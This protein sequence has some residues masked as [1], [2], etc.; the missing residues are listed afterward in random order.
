MGRVYAC[1][2]VVSSGVG[3]G[4]C[5]GCRCTPKMSRKIF[6]VAAGFPHIPICH[7]CLNCTKFGL[8]ILRK[9]IKIVATMQMSY[10]KAKMH[11]IRF[12]LGPDP[13]GGAY[14]TPPYPLA[15][16]RGPT[17]KGLSLIHI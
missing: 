8:L 17:S 11:Q 5:T 14:S 10:F 9:I 4:G 13:V 3:R 6:S 12:R 2:P 1:D 15:G 7:Y 16:L